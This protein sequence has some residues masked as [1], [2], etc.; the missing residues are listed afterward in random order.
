MLL[1]VNRMLNL[2][3]LTSKF[4]HDRPAFVGYTS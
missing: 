2:C 1:Q 4:Q 3:Y